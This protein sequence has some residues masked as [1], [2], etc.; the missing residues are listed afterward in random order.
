MDVYSVHLPA[1]LSIHRAAW[2]GTDGRM[3]GWTDGQT[4]GRTDK[5][6]DGQTDGWMDGQMDGWM[7]GR[8]NGQTDGRTNGRNERPYVMR[9][10]GFTPFRADA[11]KRRHNL[12]RSCH[13]KHD[14]KL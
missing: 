2:G 13:L 9:Q 14:A 5:R 7:D 3:D 4:D 12:E 8:T 10:E 6:M 1:R 11:K